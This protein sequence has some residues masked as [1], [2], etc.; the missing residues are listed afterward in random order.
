MRNARF[1][2]DFDDFD[3]D[4]DDDDY[5]YGDIL[6]EIKD[7]PP[8]LPRRNV[9]RLTLDEFLAEGR[10]KSA[11]T[12]PPV[13]SRTPRTNP[14]EALALA[15]A[16]YTGVGVVAKPTPSGDVHRDAKEL[17]ALARAKFG[18]GPYRP[19][20]SMPAGHGIQLQLTELTLMVG[21]LI[22]EV[23]ELRDMIKVK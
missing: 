6:D 18:A 19:A 21:K 22:R 7:V 11:D 16:K 15:R 4:D 12:P 23:A 9:S 3:D 1:N 8:P 2:D 14:R 10:D 5:N 13:V 20:A 17:L